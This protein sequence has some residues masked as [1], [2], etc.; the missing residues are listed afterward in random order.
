MTRILLVEDNEMNRDMLSRRLSRRGFD[1]LIAENGKAGV[2]LATSERPDVILMDMSLPVMDGWEATRQIKANP[3]TSG[4]PV[5]ALTA[6]AM[7]SDRD[8]ALDAGCDDY[9]S[10][11]VDLTQLVRKIE[12]LLT[13]SP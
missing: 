2:E 3:L 4:I 12:Q 7:A 1:V 5:I 6:H 11:P 8:M 10:K 9:D 13:A